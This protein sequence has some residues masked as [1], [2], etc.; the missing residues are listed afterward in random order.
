MIADLVLVAIEEASKEEAF[1]SKEEKNL[2]VEETSR[3]NQSA[4]IPGKNLRGAFSLIELGN[5]TMIVYIQN[6]D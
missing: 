2:E 4:L 1:R 5:Y 6:R 3:E